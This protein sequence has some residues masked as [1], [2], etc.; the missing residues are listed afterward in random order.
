MRIEAILIPADFETLPKRD[1]SDTVAVVFDV[2]RATS[3][4]LTALANG[5]AEIVPVLTL[6][7]AFERK[8]AQP[9]AL[10]GGE[11]DGVRPDGFD[12]GN[13]PME[14][15]R[16]RVEG[17]VVVHTT[18]NGT[19]AL[20]SCAGC[21]EVLLGSLLNLAAVAECVRRLQEKVLLLACAGTFSHFALEDGIAAGALLARLGAS[22][23]DMSPAARSLLHLWRSV[24]KD[25]IEA[26]RGSRNGLKLARIGLGADVDYCARVDALPVVAAYVNGSSRL[27]AL[28]M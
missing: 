26:V 7:D 6:E 1:L 9:G 25:A 20:M 21:R 5:A 8:R 4:E 11:R 2:L 14:Y 24:E 28:Q 16:E 3:T 15:T 23:E 13:S 17:R 22:A 19:V 18:T 27:Q 12:F 10:L